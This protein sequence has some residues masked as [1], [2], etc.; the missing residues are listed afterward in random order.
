MPQEDD[1][2]CQSKMCYGSKVCADKKGQATK[3]YKEIDK[4]CQTN[5][6]M[7]PVKPQMGVWSEKPTKQYSF[8]KKHTPLFKG[9]SCKSIRIHNKSKYF[10]KYCQENENNVMWSV[11][12]TNDVWLLKAVVPYEY[13][14]MHNDKN[15]QSTRC[16]K[17]PVRPVYKYDKNCQL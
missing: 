16:Y 3:Y 13:R 15:C 9:N 14:S 4:N 1:K 6:I 7:Q 11:T 17:S 10:D 8:K 12:N 2:N 5:G